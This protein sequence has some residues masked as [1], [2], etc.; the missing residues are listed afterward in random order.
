MKKMM[1]TTM[2][3]MLLMVTMMMMMMMMMEGVISTM[4]I[5]FAVVHGTDMKNKTW[6]TK[7]R[8][9]QGL[10]WRWWLGCS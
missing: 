10:Q 9:R 3:T 2:I 6:M 5:T 4:V 8:A 1:M 7:R